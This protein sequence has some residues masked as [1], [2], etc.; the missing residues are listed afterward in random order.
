MS[1]LL[2]QCVRLWLVKYV[3]CYLL[4][5]ASDD[6]GLKEDE[7]ENNEV[8]D[9]ERTEV[10]QLKAFC[11]LTAFDLNKLIIKWFQSLQ[12][13]KFSVRLSDFV[14]FFVSF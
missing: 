4:Q 9:M 12:K 11:S 2:I 10:L 6:E 7:E 3:K 13:K 5:A 14:V 8:E 1:I